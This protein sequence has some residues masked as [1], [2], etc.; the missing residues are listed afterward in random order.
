[1]AIFFFLVGP[2]SSGKS[3]IGKKMKKKFNLKFLDADNFHSLKNIKKM[4]KGIKLRYRDRLPWLLRIN[5]K[6]RQYN[7]LNERY[8][9]ACSGLK[10]KYRDILSKKLDSVYFI[11]LKCTDSKLIKRI[12]SRN[13]FFPKHLIYDQIANFETSNDLIN[14]NANKNVSDVTKIV[15]R[16]I[17]NIIY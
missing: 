15:T 7:N 5:K 11:Y 13:H 16:K 2:A 1:M 9:I 14:V 17:K 12:Y 6:L 4:K 10:K 3:T 8:I